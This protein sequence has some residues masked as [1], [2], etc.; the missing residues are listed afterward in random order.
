MKKI[1]ILFSLCVLPSAFVHSQTELDSVCKSNLE[2]IFKVL[3]FK[4]KYETVKYIYMESRYKRSLLFTKNGGILD[5]YFEYIKGFPYPKE[6]KDSL[7]N[8]KHEWVKVER[9]SEEEV[10]SF[11]EQFNYTTEEADK[12]YCDFIQNIKLEKTIYLKCIDAEL[13]KGEDSEYAK[14]KIFYDFKPPWSSLLGPSITKLDYLKV[15]KEFVLND[16][17]PVLPDYMR[18]KAYLKCGCKI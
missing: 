4:N 16:D 6:Q 17:E 11:L 7:S 12:K 3:G 2:N 13:A 5:Y 1:F 9:M 10:K 8:K 15:F 14:D 18:V